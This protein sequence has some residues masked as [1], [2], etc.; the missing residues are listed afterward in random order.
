LTF[1]ATYPSALPAGT[2]FYK[3][4][5]TPG[6]ATPHWYTHPATIVGNTLTFSVTDGGAGDD[7][8]VVNGVI[9][10]DGGPGAPV[11]ANTN[12]IPTL[13]E[14][15]LLLLAMLLGGLGWRGVKRQGR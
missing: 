5:P 4:G 8:G 3:F 10:D 12:A 6:N 1:T 15:A 14:W 7:D 9:V 13:N 2:V 11:V